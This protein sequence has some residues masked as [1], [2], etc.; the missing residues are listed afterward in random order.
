MADL[1][2][3]INGDVKGYQD[4]LKKAQ[5]ETEDLE[6]SLG[7][8]AKVSGIA[9][10]ALTAEIGFSVKAYA[11]SEV[12]TNKLVR[13][14]QNQGIYSK[15]LAQDYQ[16]QATALQELSGVSDEAVLA[17]Q[18]SVQA[19]IGEATVTKELTLAIADFAAA[20]GIDLVSAADLAAKSI[21]TGTN[22]LTRYGIQLDTSASV[23]DKMNKFISESTRLFEGQAEAQGKG[24]G[25]LQVL[26]ETFGDFQEQI[27]QRF[28]P[29]IT[30]GA[31]A[32]KDFFVSL[33]QNKFLLDLI[34]SMI[35]AGVVVGG[36]VTTV[37]LAS[38]A[39]LQ[40]KA[41]LT[42][43]GVATSV[44]TL[45]VRALV[46][47]TGLGLLVM[48]ATQVA[49]NWSTVWPRMAGIFAGF[50][51]TVSKL[52][53]G[54]SSVLSGI[55][56]FKAEKIKQ[57]L[58]EIKAAFAAGFDEYS[59]TVNQKLKD[60]ALAEN[61]IEQDKLNQNKKFKEEYAETERKERVARF[62][63]LL[64]ENEEF[65]L[66]TQ[67]QQ[68]LF[69]ETNA[70]KQT[71]IVANEKQARAAI[72]KERLDMQT[73]A[74]NDFLINQEKFGVAYALINKIMND[75]IFQGAKGAFQEMAQFQ[76][77]SNATLKGIGKAAA[78]ANIIIKTAES[79]MNIYAGFS[80]IP[81]IGPALGVAGAAAA[82]AFGGEQVS[83]VLAAAEGGLITG[84]IPG[85][86]SVPVLAQ[87]GE[88]VVPTKNYEEVV[89]SV[90]SRRNAEGGGES[91][92]GGTAHIVLSL[93]DNLIDFI[94]TKLVE[95]ERISLSIQGA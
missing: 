53:T 30:A 85:V 67:E 48:I 84:G 8:I 42:A 52:G 60:Q 28:T 58:S 3:R 21:G 65:E 7:Q 25:V 90:A 59:I 38:I 43:A 80:Q 92:T 81:F 22:A 10:A 47:A 73:K 95:R 26:A 77:S 4:A 69:R 86:D 16:D 62:E 5:A 83:Q 74:N 79:A 35:T 20:K 45:G 9:F 78:V 12:A 55:F 41:A 18:T 23:Q 49:L 87:R 44:M 29:A 75:A 39:F 94:E 31:T 34:A 56:T 27:G 19:Y 63:A 24:L 76:Q 37:A 51:E 91:G 89:N 17:A 33:N 72:A 6:K 82:V 61:Q 36:L 88:L 1:V 93:R 50:V 46:G 71:E 11:Q 64:K 54:L 40:F 70:A 32:L 14:L 15:S 57:G 66:L 13:A 2:I 68:A